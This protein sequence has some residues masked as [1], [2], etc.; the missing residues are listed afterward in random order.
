MAAGR[1]LRREVRVALS[2]RAQPIWFRVLKWVVLIVISVKL[3]PTPYFW[4]WI[5]GSITLALTLHMIWRWK[6]RAWTQAWGGWDD[7]GTADR[8]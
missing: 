6:T 5:V 1:T 8:E 7:V 3:W 4:W 2:P